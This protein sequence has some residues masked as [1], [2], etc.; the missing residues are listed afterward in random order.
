MSATYTPPRDEAEKIA[1][2]LARYPEA[3]RM[4]DEG[5]ARPKVAQAV[6]LLRD[7]L[8]GL[9]IAQQMGLSRSQAY[10]LLN[11]PTDEKNRARKAKQNGTCERC[12]GETSYGNGTGPA[13]LCNDC[14]RGQNADRNAEIER[15]W[16]AGETGEEIA[17]ALGLSYGA[18][19][20]WINDARQRRGRDISLHRR[21]NR[22]L[23]PEI[24]R[25]WNAGCSG[26]AIGKKL[27]ISD[28]NAYFMIAAMRDAGISMRTGW[29]RRGV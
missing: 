16:E 6:R 4:T 2:R 26:S 27:G 5:T 10:Q 25:L 7:G 29:A 3:V 22:E 13:R 28:R 9:D 20:G 12:G 17:A 24:E 23:W 1:R 19:R 18:V 11:D 21:R 14:F 15:R 8:T